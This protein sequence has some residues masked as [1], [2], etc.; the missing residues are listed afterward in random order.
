MMTDS[1]G[2]I[3][4]DCLPAVRGQVGGEGGLQW[5]L[6]GPWSCSIHMWCMH[7][8]HTSSSIRT[9]LCVCNNWGSGPVYHCSDPC[10]QVLH[11]FDD[12]TRGVHGIAEQTEMISFGSTF[13][14]Q[15]QLFLPT[16]PD[17]QRVLVLY[18]SQLQT[19][20]P[21]SRP[22]FFILSDGGLAA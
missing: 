5:R 16:Q 13:D 3:F 4:W 9:V 20:H 6:C 14:G 7:T 11:W 21:P 12:M 18:L 19:R 15:S 17:L 2:Q 8:M 10:L 1:L 22:G